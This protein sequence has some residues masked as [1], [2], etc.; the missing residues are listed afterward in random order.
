M[1]A[2]PR[3]FVKSSKASHLRLAF[4]LRQKLKFPVGLAWGL[5]GRAGNVGKMALSP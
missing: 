3:Y 5:S 4:L 2:G 1:I